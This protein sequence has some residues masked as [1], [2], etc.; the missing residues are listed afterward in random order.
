MQ[1]KVICSRQDGK[2]REP[3]GRELVELAVGEQHVV[4]AFVDRAAELVL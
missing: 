1:A 3:I 4:R 2:R